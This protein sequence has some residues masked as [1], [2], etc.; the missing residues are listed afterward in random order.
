MST[1]LDLDALVP[2]GRKIKFGGEE[3]EV[4]P[5]RTQHVLRLGFLGQKMGDMSQLPENE[6]D[7]LV[8]DLEKEIKKCIP[9]LEGKDLTAAQ[10]MQLLNL[11][12]E[13]G[14]PTDAAELKKKGITV[15][16]PKK[17]QRS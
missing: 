4:Q 17:D 1:V 15:D 14:M 5:P 12:V 9:Q 11:I 3:I 13:M 2:Q 6:L 10:L 16:T 8:S 7:E